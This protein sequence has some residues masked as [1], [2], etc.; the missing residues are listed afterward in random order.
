MK[1]SRMGAALF[2]GLAL[3]TSA[4]AQPLAGSGPSKWFHHEKKNPNR[5]KVTHHPK[6]THRV[7]KQ[8]TRKHS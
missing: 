8:K 2:L 7:A 1:L 5:N 4:I 3:C 6:P